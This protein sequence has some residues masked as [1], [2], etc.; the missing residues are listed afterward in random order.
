MAAR[1]QMFDRHMPNLTTG[2]W[3][4]RLVYPNTVDYAPG[5]LRPDITS[6]L[7]SCAVVWLGVRY[8]NGAPVW[9]VVATWPDA[10]LVC[11]RLFRQ[12]WQYQAQLA[13]AVAELTI[14]NHGRLC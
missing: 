12:H 6:A 14:D 10:R 13:E 3:Q 9:A 11:R 7:E 8:R 4:T 5:E 1:V 2:D